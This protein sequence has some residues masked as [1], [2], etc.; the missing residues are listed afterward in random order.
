VNMSRGIRPK[1]RHLG[2]ENQIGHRLYPLNATRE[3]W[4]NHEVSEASTFHTY[5]F[6]WATLLLQSE[7]N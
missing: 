2:L 3:T 1:G 4:L 6:I 7:R 5:R